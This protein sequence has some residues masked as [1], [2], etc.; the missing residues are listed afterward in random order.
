MR[1]VYGMKSLFTSIRFLRS[2]PYLS[3]KFSLGTFNGINNFHGSSWPLL[4]ITKATRKVDDLYFT[5]TSYSTMPPP[6]SRDNI[7]LNKKIISLKTVEDQLELFDSCKNSAGIVNRLTMLHRIAKIT[8][9]DKN[10]NKC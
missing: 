7:Q 8:E 2:Y 3:Q 1:T 5:S 10:R 4:G 9:R 6:P